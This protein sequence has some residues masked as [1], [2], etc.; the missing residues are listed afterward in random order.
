LALSTFHQLRAD[1]QDT[2]ACHFGNS[3]V[4]EH[5]VPPTTFLSLVA[6]QYLCFVL[7]VS[8]VVNLQSLRCDGRA[9]Q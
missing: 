8:L 5:T 1:H 4:I 2:M 9:K 6:A 7:F 3:L